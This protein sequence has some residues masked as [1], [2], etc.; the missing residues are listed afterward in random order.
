MVDAGCLKINPS[1]KGFPGKTEKRTAFAGPHTREIPLNIHG[2]RPNS[3][4]FIKF[5]LKTPCISFPVS[6]IFQ[7]PLVS[8]GGTCGRRKLPKPLDLFFYLWYSR[9][10]YYEGL[11]NLREFLVH[12]HN[13]SVG[14]FWQTAG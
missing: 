14:S 9:S 12:A 2:I 13:Q 3:G 8:R 11:L 6:G 4:N 7:T 5:F 10:F 1:E